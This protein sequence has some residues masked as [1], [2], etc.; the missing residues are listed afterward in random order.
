M[1]NDD[2]VKNE[3]SAIIKEIAYAVK[4]VEI[5]DDC[6]NSFLLTTKEGITYQLTLHNTGLEVVSVHGDSGSENK[7]IV[8][9]GDIFETV[10][11]FLNKV[12]FSYRKLFAEKLSEKLTLLPSER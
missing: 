2:L 8:A 6:I 1:D 3:I 4:K 9:V 11:S 10:Y 7:I 5:C 12:S